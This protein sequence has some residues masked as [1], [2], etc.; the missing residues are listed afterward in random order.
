MK[1]RV[2]K[3]LPKVESVCQANLDWICLQKTGDY[4]F[5]YRNFT[6]FITRFSSNEKENFAV[7]NIASDEKTNIVASIKEVLNGTFSDALSFR[8][9]VLMALQ[10]VPVLAYPSVENT[11]DSFE[12]YSEKGTVYEVVR[13]RDYVEL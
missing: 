5:E 11:S 4:E 1:E 7:W 9:N 12:Y 3:Q 13:L 10:E 6:A 2:I 8:L